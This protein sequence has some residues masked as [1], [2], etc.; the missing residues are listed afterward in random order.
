[1]RLA[2]MLISIEARRTT[3]ADH[4][5][6]LRLDAATA[7]ALLG[8]AT[9][10]DDGDVP[11][12]LR[13]AAHD[14]ASGLAVLHVL[15]AGLPGN[16]SSSVPSSS[17]RP[18]SSRF[19]VVADVT[20]A[21]VSARPVFIGALQTIESALWWSDMVWELPVGTDLSPGTFVFTIDG[22]FVG[23]IADDGDRLA[24][25]PAETLKT[26]ADRL[27]A[28][29]LKNFGYLGIDAQPLT[30]GTAAAT[31]AQSGVIVT[32]VDPKGP[33]AEQ[34]QV[35]DVIE[36]AGD[37]SLRDYGEWRAIAARIAPG[38]VLS[39]V[40]RRDGEVRSSTVT[41]VA[42]AARPEVPALGLT[43]RTIR[44]TGAEVTAVAA[45]SAAALAGIRPGDLITLIDDRR[46]PTAAEVTQ[47]FAAAKSGRP[48]L[49]AVTRGTVHH[50]LTLDKR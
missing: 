43:M 7:V 15:P 46:A 48:V 21:G 9:I 12:T 32:A 2:P 20:P 47:R 5:A 39:L 49:A 34:V 17:R 18:P 30:A 38:A 37:Q 6:A 1:M 8:D 44:G 29:G 4:V 28:G 24:I 31:G 33:A 41:A 35:A 45:G 13:V 36:M 25:V 23:M 26:A 42:V 27:T 3:S 11:P 40:V 16:W 10:A 14:P 50:V 22:A 19:L